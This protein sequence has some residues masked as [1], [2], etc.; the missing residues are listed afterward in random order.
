MKQLLFFFILLFFFS[1]QSQSFNIS[2]RDFS[3]PDSI[4]KI[5]KGYSLKQLPQLSYRLTHQFDNEVDKFR[6][7]FTWVS[8]NISA[9][10][11]LVDKVMRKRR[12][13]RS[14]SLA[15]TTWNSSFNRKS[16]NESLLNKS[17][18]CTG[19][20]YLIHEMALMVGIESEIINGYLKTSNH[21]FPNIDVPN[22]SWNAVK[23]NDKWYLC[24]ATLAS[25]YFFVNEDKFIFEYQDS[26]FLASPEIFAHSH[27]P[28]NKK[29]TLLKH[30]IIFEAFVDGP[31]IY[32][33]AF[34]N[35]I[36]PMHPKTIFVEA[37][38]GTLSEFKFKLC[39]HQVL[40]KTP[41]ISMITNDQP[42]DA[43]VIRDGELIKVSYAFRHKGI[44]DVHFNI[45][46][47]TFTSY[48]VKVSK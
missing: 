31:I 12:K 26:Y 30:P 6:A 1:I 29:W 14:D 44:Y 10:D 7:I 4:A 46:G 34:D 25:G 17:T 48:S 20:A 33:G 16:F 35:H 45:G 43:E 9:S 37:K 32:D 22:H 21:P 8:T 5:F 23:L 42:L 47:N 39:R 24:D 36:T 18:I 28:L 19:Y 13:Y 41:V 2:E 11:R 3:K 27:L 40:S 38:K 15:Y